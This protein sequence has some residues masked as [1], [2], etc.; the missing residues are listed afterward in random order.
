MQYTLKQKKSFVNGHT[1]YCHRGLQREADQKSSL[2]SSAECNTLSINLKKHF[3]ILPRTISGNL[4]V[5]N[6]T[7]YYRPLEK[8]SLTRQ[9]RHIRS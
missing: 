6:T 4:M 2:Q 1:I 3:A 9:Q 5:Q 8:L 7:N